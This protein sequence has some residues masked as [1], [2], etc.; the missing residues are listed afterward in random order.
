MTLQWASLI[1]TGTAWVP[2]TMPMSY[3]S[4]SSLTH[5]TQS[6]YIFPP[7][8]SFSYIE[9]QIFR[10]F[11]LTFVHILRWMNTICWIKI[12]FYSIKETGMHNVNGTGGPIL[13]LQQGWFSMTWLTSAAYNWRYLNCLNYNAFSYNWGC[14]G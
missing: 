2:A 14:F 12:Y 6:S 13:H 11:L 10:L 9:C 7:I 1:I 4:K 8:Y 3:Q 5:L